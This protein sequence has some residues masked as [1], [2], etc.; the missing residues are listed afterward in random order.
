MRHG[1][2][3]CLSETRKGCVTL[4]FMPSFLLSNLNLAGVQKKQNYTK[5]SAPVFP[6]AK[7]NNRSVFGLL[8]VKNHGLEIFSR[9]SNVSTN[10]SQST[11][12]IFVAL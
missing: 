11:Q 5:A 8:A 3:S 12:F 1:R 7:K 4:L 9:D 10:V 6:I 2:F